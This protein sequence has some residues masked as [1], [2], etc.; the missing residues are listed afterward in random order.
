MPKLRWLK[1]ADG[2]RGLGFYCPGCKMYHHMQVEEGPN[3]TDGPIWQWNQDMDKP[4]FTP[5]L[6]VNMGHSG[7][8]HLMV[9]EGR[10][11]YLNDSQHELAGRVVDMME[12][13]D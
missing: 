4:T 9:K 10:I 2:G 7:Q 3:Y 11:S 8:C 1:M 6:G 13:K 5:S 12:E